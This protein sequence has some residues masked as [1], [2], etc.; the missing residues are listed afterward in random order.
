M[1]YLLYGFLIYFGIRFVFNF[2]IPVIR[3]TRQFRSQV[4]QFQQNMQQQNGFQDSSRQTA[5][6]DTHKAAA[7]K[8]DYIDFEEIKS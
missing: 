4:K 5:E 6:A 2:L 3:T 1:R 7:D 8:G